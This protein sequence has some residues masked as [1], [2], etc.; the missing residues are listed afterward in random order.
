[1]LPYDEDYPVLVDWCGSAAMLLEIDYLGSSPAVLQRLSQGAL[2]YSAWLDVNSHNQLSFAAGGE[3]ILTIDAFFPGSP[4]DHPGI[5]QWPE[6]Q[7]MT[8]FFVEFEER[9]EDYD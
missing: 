3:L 8:D 1:M 2:A 5:G 9:D 6:P 4:E 7:E